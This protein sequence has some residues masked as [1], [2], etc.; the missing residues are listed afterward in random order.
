MSAKRLISDF[1]IKGC[2]L[3]H[4]YGG[5]FQKLTRAVLDEIDL[6][7]LRDTERAASFADRPQFYRYIHESCINGS[8]VDYLEF[9]VYKGD[10][11]REWIGLN[12][13]GESRFFGF[14]SFEGLPEYW[15]PG[16]NRGHFDVQGKIPQVDDS[17]VTFVKGWFDS[18]IPTFAG[19]FCSRNR[20]ILHLD[21]DLYGSTMLA[22]VHFTPFMSKGTLLIFD[23]FYDR[24][25][26][27]KA[28]RDWL[29]MTG[30]TF[31]VVAEVD[32]FAKI[33]AELQ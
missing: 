24:D 19:Q 22:L 14:D 33:C 8:A 30:K 3:R 1:A 2:G 16:Q 12:T 23:E 25:H 28:F 15:R 17:R 32:G 29:K 4:L 10:S 26:E 9:G 11:I 6:Q 7:H 18:T 20:L 27:F 5:R 21:A 13:H 31:R